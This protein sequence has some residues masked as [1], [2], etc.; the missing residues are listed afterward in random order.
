MHKIFCFNRMHCTDVAYEKDNRLKGKKT[1][2]ADQIQI[3]SC[4]LGLGFKMTHAGHTWRFLR[5]TGIDSTDKCE[6]RGPILLLRIRVFHPYIQRINVFQACS[7]RDSP[8][9]SRANRWLCHSA[10]SNPLTRNAQRKLGNQ[11]GK[12]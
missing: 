12:M 11:Q 3:L 2:N 7:K 1:A 10:T 6:K 8:T 4:R 5:S 9:V